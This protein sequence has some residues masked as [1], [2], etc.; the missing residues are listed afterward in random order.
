MKK[1][2]LVDPIYFS[3]E[4]NIHLG[5]MSLRDVLKSQY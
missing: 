5:T 1:I 2:V 3:V 4:D